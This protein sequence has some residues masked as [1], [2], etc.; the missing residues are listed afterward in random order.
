MANMASHGVAA[1]DS[2]SAAT[3]Q[4]AGRGFNSH[5]L[6]IVGC[7]VLGLIF[8][9]L[10]WYGYRYHNPYTGQ[11]WSSS[12]NAWH[13]GAAAWVPIVLMVLVGVLAAA[14]MLG[15]GRAAGLGSLSASTALA[16]LSAVSLLLIIVRWIT[17]PHVNYYLDGY[18]VWS[19]GARYGLIIGL[20]ASIVMTVL[21]LRRLRASGQPAAGARYEPDAAMAGYGARGADRS[22]VADRERVEAGRTDRIDTGRVDT[23]RVDTG[24]A[25]Q[26]GY[27]TAPTTP[28]APERPPTTADRNEPTDRGDAYPERDYPS[29]GRADRDAGDPRARDTWNDR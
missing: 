6:P 19:S 9:F 4:H 8:S 15:G 16:V 7:G 17:L 10:P 1:Q 14:H 5:N 11:A 3:Q 18:H 26:P 23:G 27:P 28:S 29:S 21:T 13:A 25:D 2:P 20:V 12:V 24:R 22:R